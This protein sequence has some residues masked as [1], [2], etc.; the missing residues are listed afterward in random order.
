MNSIR[1]AL[2]LLVASVIITLSSACE[3]EPPKLKR[4]HRKLIDS[5]Y[6]EKRNILRKELDSLCDIKFAAEIEQA[7]DSILQQ[8]MAEIKRKIEADAKKN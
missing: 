6:Q 7:T 3:K 1:T 8:R 4:S 5:L 2:F